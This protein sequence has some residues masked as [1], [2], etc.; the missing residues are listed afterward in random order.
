MSIFWWILEIVAIMKI[1]RW[2]WQNKDCA[3][4]GK[5]VLSESIYNNLPWDYIYIYIY[6]SKWFFT[7]SEFCVLHI[8]MVGF[9][10]SFPITFTT[11]SSYSENHF[12][13]TTN[14]YVTRPVLL[15][16]ISILRDRIKQMMEKLYFMIALTIA[17]ME[18]RASRRSY[19]GVLCQVIEIRI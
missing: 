4:L 1:S 14:F 3:L 15:L 2:I 12:S 16:V 6:I 13:Q 11:S 10:S 8:V 7:I 17:S 18:D 5:L 19:V 9:E